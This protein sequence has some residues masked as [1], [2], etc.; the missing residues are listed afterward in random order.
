MPN[1]ENSNRF[2]LAIYW[3]YTGQDNYGNNAVSSIPQEILVRWEDA[4]NQSY[5]IGNEVVSIDAILDTGEELLIG[6]AIWKGALIDLPSPTTNTQFYR[7]VKTDNIPDI[8]GRSFATSASLTK[9]A[10]VLPVTQ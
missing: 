6:S 7:V 8:K 3:P 4:H 2:Q 5:T 1:N 10:F 9:S